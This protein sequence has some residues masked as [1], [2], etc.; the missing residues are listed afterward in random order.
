MD[1]ADLYERPPGPRPSEVRARW[2]S[3]GNVKDLWNVLIS[4]P[5]DRI[6]R[7]EVFRHLAQALEVRSQSDPEA[8]ARAAYSRMTAFTS[9]LLMRCH[10]YLSTYVEQ[11]GR[12]VRMRG[13]P[14]GD[15]PEAAVA[16]LI[17]KVL[18][19]QEHL[20][21]LLTAEAAVARQWSLV[22]RNKGRRD[23]A[24]DARPRRTRH[25]GGPTPTSEGHPPAH[26]HEKLAGRLA[27]VTDGHGPPNGD[28]RDD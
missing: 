7:E 5:W 24:P 28:A 15:L 4:T 17:P 16:K 14:P 11:S 23:R 9:A 12:A 20:S 8:F 2:A 21:L 26:A 27:G 19:M 1:D 22:G 18:A 3:E 25:D 13:Q 10:L 6:D